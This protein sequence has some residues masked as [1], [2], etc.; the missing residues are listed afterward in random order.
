MTNKEF[1]RTYPLV[2][3][4]PTDKTV[5]A[6]LLLTKAQE[7]YTVVFDHK[8]DGDTTIFTIMCDRTSFAN[9]YFFLGQKIPSFKDIFFID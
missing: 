2:I 4:V 6:I 9:C 5:A 7:T 1:L 8:E 3:A